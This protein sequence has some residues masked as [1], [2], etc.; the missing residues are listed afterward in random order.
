ML[1]FKLYVKN[2]NRYRNFEQIIFHKTVAQHWSV[3]ILNKK[4]IKTINDEKKLLLSS[5]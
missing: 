2:L 5:N 1:N 3:Y 4:K